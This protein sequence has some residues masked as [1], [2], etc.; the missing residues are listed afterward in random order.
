MRQLPIIRDKSTRG[1]TTI[2]AINPATTVGR[3][4]RG[5]VYGESSDIVGCAGTSRW[6]LFKEPVHYPVVAPRDLAKY[7]LNNNNRFLKRTILL[8]YTDLI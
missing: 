6:D 7:C 3:R 2:D 1:V 4:I 8:P 5:Q